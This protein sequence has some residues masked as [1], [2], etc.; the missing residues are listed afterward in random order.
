MIEDLESE[1]TR[2]LKETS[3]NDNLAVAQEENV[4]ED[5][6]EEAKAINEMGNDLKD[7]KNT[8]AYVE[9]MNIDI[10]NINTNENRNK[11]Y[12]KQ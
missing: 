8:E 10:E 11:A 1:L 2:S 5:I 4:D 6:N 7:E 9:K 3:N 12:I